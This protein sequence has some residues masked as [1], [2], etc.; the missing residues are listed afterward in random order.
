MRGV[1]E[2]LALEAEL[3]ILDS[4]PLLAVTDSAVL[5]AMVDGTLLVID[6]GRSRRRAV[7][8]VDNRSPGPVPMSWESPS[9]ACR[10]KPARRTTGTAATEPER[11]P[12]RVLKRRTPRR[13]VRSSE[14]AHTAAAGLG[15]V[16]ARVAFASWRGVRVHR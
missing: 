13:A 15:G 9:I 10:A 3:I 8:R 4:P 1:L 7:R 5:S 16:V 12:R 11:M 2:R 14:R 6:S